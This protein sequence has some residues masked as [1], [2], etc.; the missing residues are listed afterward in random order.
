MIITG[1]M[2]RDDALQRIEQPAWDR[3]TIERDFEYVATK[4][5]LSVDEL[6]GYLH[7][8]SKSWRDYRNRQGLI[9]AG[10]IAMQLVGLEKRTIR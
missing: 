8:P 9:K 10:T 1:Q 7:G 6:K 5:G 3:E 4:L 2:T